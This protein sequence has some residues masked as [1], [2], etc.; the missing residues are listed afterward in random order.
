M[1]VLQKLRLKKKL[2]DELILCELEV[3]SCTFLVLTFSLLKD[4]KKKK[5][6]VCEKE[7]TKVRVATYC[8]WFSIVLRSTNTIQILSLEQREVSET[9]R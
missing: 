6:Q 5:M 4:E 2:F 9:G 3:E 7:G 1:R 8:N